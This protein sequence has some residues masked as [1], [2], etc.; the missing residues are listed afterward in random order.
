[1]WSQDQRAA[2]RFTVPS[3]I[4]DEKAFNPF[5]RCREPT[6]RTFVEGRGAAGGAAASAM[7]EEDV[8]RRL[9]NLKDNFAGSSRPWIPGGGSLPG[10]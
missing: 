6:V 5:M 3:T 1:M 8:M 7:A 2:G 4:A 9:R 10:L